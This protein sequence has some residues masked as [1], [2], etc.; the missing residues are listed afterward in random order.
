MGGTRCTRSGAGTHGLERTR[1]RAARQLRL[2]DSPSS[3]ILKPAPMGVRHRVQ[4]SSADAAALR[5]H[6]GR[7]RSGGSLRWRSAGR[8]CR[9]QPQRT[10]LQ[11]RDSEDS[12]QGFGRSASAAASRSSQL[13]PHA[14]PGV[15]EAEEQSSSDASLTA[16]EA[17]Y[18]RGCPHQPHAIVRP[19]RLL[20]TQRGRAV[21][22]RVPTIWRAPCSNGRSCHPLGRHLTSGWSGSRGP[23]PLYTVY[24]SESTTRVLRCSRPESIRRPHKETQCF[25]DFL[26]FPQS[27]RHV[28]PGTPS[29]HDSHSSSR[30]RTNWAGISFC[31]KSLP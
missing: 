26:S 19:G 29:T 17:A 23:I 12:V 4:R 1:G 18:Q 16:D 6:A 24:N 25:S 14:K 27:S 30:R 20:L 5:P 28:T 22:R 8:A 31:T 15:P 2:P 7:A 9:S 10:L 21:A 3:A 11:R 13:C